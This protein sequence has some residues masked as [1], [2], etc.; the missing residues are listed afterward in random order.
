MPAS[1]THPPAYPPTH[2]PTHPPPRSI[3]GNLVDGYSAEAARLARRG[4]PL[5]SPRNR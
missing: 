2:P 1:S 3:W 5:L 4:I